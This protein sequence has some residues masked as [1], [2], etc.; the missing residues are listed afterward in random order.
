[1]A[2]QAVGFRYSLGVPRRA[3]TL[4]ELLVVIAI[5]ALLIGILLPALGAARSAAK[6]TQ[7][8]ARL[9]QLGVGVAAYLVDY[10]ELLPQK[11]GHAPDGSLVVVGALF[12]GKKGRL[13]FFDINT[14]GAEGRPLNPYV[15]DAKVPPDSTD[16]VVD[17][18]FF[19]SPVDKG[20]QDTGVPIPTMDR[21]DSMYDLVGSSYTLNDHTLDGEEDA[22]LVPTG[23]GRMP[24]VNNT[25]RT[26]MIATHT[27]YNYQQGG[28]KGMWWFKKG[29]VEANM[30]YVDGH[31]RMRV[32]VPAPIGTDY[33]NST[34]DYSFRP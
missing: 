31:S 34:P 26:W 8:G 28:D 4:I 2:S 33:G 1:M 22:T 20:A 27:I 30:L 16:E 11:L 12:G 5:I 3:F 21:T 6:V 7:C 14:V 18:P 13:P 17:L 15:G 23:G 24:N 19:R 25:S 29:Q 32:A 10:K 9:Q